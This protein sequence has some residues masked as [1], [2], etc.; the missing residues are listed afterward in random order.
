MSL[1]SP[2]NSLDDSRHLGHPIALPRLNRLAI[3][4]GIACGKSTFARCLA[5]LGCEV[6]DADDVVHWLEAPGG[7][8]VPMILEAFGPTVIASD[9]GVCRELLGRL[10]FADPLAR[11]RL[12]GIIHPMVRAKLDDWFQRAPEGRL[13]FAVVP[14]L[15]E[16]SWGEEWDLIVCI[17]CH[18]AEQARRLMARGFT[19]EEAAGR[20]RAQWPIEEK[21]RVSDRVIWND[22]SVESLRREAEHLVRDLSEKQA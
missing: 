19:A 10:V 8:A 7:C 4:G 17:A 11:Q 15:F 5:D 1:P 6:L 21:A 18:A 3:T 13:Q 20:M 14:L 12:N 22:D 9:G 2:T 16:V